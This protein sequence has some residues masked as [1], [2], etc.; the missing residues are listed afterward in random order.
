[1]F[2]SKQTFFKLLAERRSDVQKFLQTVTWW[3]SS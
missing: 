2:K 1:M 3:D